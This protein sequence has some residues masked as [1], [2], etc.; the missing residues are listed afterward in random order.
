MA[1]QLS[2]ICNPEQVGRVFA[3]AA[4]EKGNKLKAKNKHAVILLKT[5]EILIPHLMKE[6]RK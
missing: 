1:L 3:K 4:S 5:I 6:E 2:V